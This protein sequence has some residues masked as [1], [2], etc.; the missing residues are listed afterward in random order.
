MA[1]SRDRLIDIA[2]NMRTLTKSQQQLIAGFRVEGPFLSPVY[3]GS[4]VR[5]NLQIPDFEL[6]DADLLLIDNDLN[7]HKVI[8][9]GRVV[10]LSID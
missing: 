7:L 8:K 10:N 1:L 3:C 9:Q 4:Q 2:E 6:Y 5:D